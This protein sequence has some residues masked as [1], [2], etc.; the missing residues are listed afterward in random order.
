MDLRFPINCRCGG[1]L[2]VRLCSCT[3]VAQ[4]F[5]CVFY[6]QTNQI[7]C[8]NSVALIKLSISPLLTHLPLLLIMIRCDAAEHCQYSEPIS[9][10]CTAARDTSMT[11]HPLLWLTN[12]IAACC[13]RSANKNRAAASNWEDEEEE[14]DIERLR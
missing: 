3:F 8:G 14:E 12:R 11:L 1:G 5:I 10:F 9:D 4:R 7:H 6:F 13:R 2:S